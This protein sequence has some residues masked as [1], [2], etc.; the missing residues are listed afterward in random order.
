QSFSSLCG[1]AALMFLVAKYRSSLYYQFVLDLYEFGTAKL[2]GLGITPSKGCRDF[3]PFGKIDPADWVALA[4]VRD[5]ENV[6]LQYSNTSD[7]AAGITLPSTLAGWLQQA[8]F[9]TVYNETNL[10]LTKGEK[11][12]RDAA[13]RKRDGAE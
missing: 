7:E 4:G 3:E 8:G 9:K 10:Y 12:L 2:N 5:S 13:K 6:I 1:P 11:N